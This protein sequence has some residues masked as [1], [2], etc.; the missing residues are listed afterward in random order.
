M[1]MEM[2]FVLIWMKLGE[3]GDSHDRL[4]LVMLFK[5]LLDTRGLFLHLYCFKFVVFLGTWR[6]C[7]E[8]LSGGNCTFSMKLKGMLK[9]WQN[10]LESKRTARGRVQQQKAEAWLAG[11]STIY[12]IF[13]SGSLAL[14]QGG[15]LEE[16]N[17]VLCTQNDLTFHV[18]LQLRIIACFTSQKKSESGKEVRTRK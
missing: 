1:K 9:H 15:L 10:I 2:C 12:T 13:F 5:W 16:C 6:C 17:K 18:T 11:S 4:L 14:P 7:V 8:N 3:G